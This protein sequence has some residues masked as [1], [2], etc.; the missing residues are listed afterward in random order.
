M[1]SDFSISLC[2][3][4]VLWLKTAVDPP[5][6]WEAVVTAL[7][8]PSVNEKYMAEQLESK[9]CASVQHVMEESSKPTSVEKS[10]GTTCLM[11]NLNTKMYT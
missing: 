2:E 5:P 1:H 10:E 4:L 7:R 6:T 8:S 11:T 9:Y 3:M